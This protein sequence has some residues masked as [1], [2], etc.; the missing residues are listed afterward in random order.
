MNYG[1]TFQCIHVCS[2]R[3]ENIPKI[4]KA[5]ASLIL[6]YDCIAAFFVIFKNSYLGLSQNPEYPYA[7][8]VTESSNHLS[9]L[10]S[11]KTVKPCPG[12]SAIND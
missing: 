11:D 6:S 10:N 8:G 4:I 3:G 7:A 9:L 2:A 5:H 1:N 12:S